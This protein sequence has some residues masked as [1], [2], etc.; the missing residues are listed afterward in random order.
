MAALEPAGGDAWTPLAGDRAL[1]RFCANADHDVCNWLTAAEGQ[2]RLCVACR[3][4]DT[5]PDISQPVA[6]R[7]LARHR[8][9]QAPPVLQPA[10][11]EAAAKDPRRRPAPWPGVRVPRRSAPSF[12]SKGDDRSRRRRGDDRA[13]RSRQRRD[14][15]AQGGIGRALPQPARPFPPRGRSSLLGHPGSRRREAR[16][17]PRRVRRRFAGL[18]GGAQAPLRAGRSA[19]IGRSASSRPTRR[20]IR[21]RISPKPGPTTCISSTRSRPRARSGSRS[22]RRSTRTAPTRPGSTSTPMSW[23]RSMRSSTPGRLLSSP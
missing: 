1:R 7:R 20:A 2:D 6:S 13:R 9:R 3:H 4:N 17:M 19:Q 16:T 10:S 23:A 15:E 12:R 8:T 11:L 21:G 14:G 18:R 5:I 22:S